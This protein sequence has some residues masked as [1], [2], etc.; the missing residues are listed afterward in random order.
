MWRC[1]AVES[2]TKIKSGSTRNQTGIP[3]AKIKGG[4]GSST[5]CQSSL[6]VPVAMLHEAVPQSSLSV[7]NHSSPSSSVLLRSHRALFSLS[8]WSDPPHLYNSPV[9]G[10]P[11]DECGGKAKASW[12]IGTGVSELELSLKHSSKSWNQGFKKRKH[13]SKQLQPL[14][15]LQRTDVADKPDTF[16]L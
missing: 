7:G 5:G 15:V 10:I 4:E 12:L 9:S 1:W 2:S 13:R 8:S 16:P 6:V 3:A 14:F 11:H